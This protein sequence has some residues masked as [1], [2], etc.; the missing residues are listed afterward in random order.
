MKD[1]YKILGVKPGASQ[2][3]IKKAYRL[4]A[5]KYH[6]DK[7]AGDAASEER[8]KEIS[9]SYIVLN[10]SIKRN[11]YDYAQGYRKSYTYRNREGQTSPTSYLLL[12]KNIK[13]RIFNAGGNIDRNALFTVISNTLSDETIDFLIY[14]GDVATNNLI[15]DEVLVAGIFLNNEH[16]PV[17]HAKLIKLADGNT[18]YIKRIAVLEEHKSQTHI[19]PEP[20]KEEKPHITIYTI[21][22]FFLILAIIVA[23]AV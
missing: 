15:M 20:Q 1:Y 11:E 8:F 14:T 10:N 17:I 7:N 12:F 3:D 19:D 2:E 16:K 23:L 9:E 22:F 6:P 18:R 5:L 21:L 4:L 13:E